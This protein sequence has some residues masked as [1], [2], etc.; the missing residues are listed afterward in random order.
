MK[1]IS[2]KRKLANIHREI[3][4]HFRESVYIADNIIDFFKARKYLIDRSHN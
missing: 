4:L 1:W 2:Q 3:P